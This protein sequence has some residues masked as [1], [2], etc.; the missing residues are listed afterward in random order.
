MLRINQHPKFCTPGIELEFSCLTQQQNRGPYTPIPELE[1]Q[2]L[3]SEGLGFTCAQAQGL[4]PAPKPAPR[5]NHTG[6]MR[7]GSA[8]LVLHLLL[9]CFSFLFPPEAPS[10]HEASTPC[11]AEFKVPA[12]SG[13][14]VNSSSFQSSLQRR[15]KHGCSTSQTQAREEGRT[16]ARDG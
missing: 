11:W 13:P 3:D 10:L 14:E 5:A 7:W 2:T 16:R 8:S 4:G 6:S 15:T 1:P 12:T 9:L